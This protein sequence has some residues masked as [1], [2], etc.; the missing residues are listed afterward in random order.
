MRELL[1]IQ[2][3]LLLCNLSHSVPEPFS[4]ENLRFGEGWANLTG[5]FSVLSYCDIRGSLH[6]NCLREILHLRGNRSARLSHA[7]GCSAMN[8]YPLH[9]WPCLEVHPRAGDPAPGGL[10][11]WLRL[12]S[13]CWQPR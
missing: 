5:K 13:S 9:P 6:F 1:K 3:C 7:I 11:R 12:L 4:P 2:L 8:L 10:H